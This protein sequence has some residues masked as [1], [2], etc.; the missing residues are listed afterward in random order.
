MFLVWHIM[1]LKIETPNAKHSVDLIIFLIR[2]LM[3]L[4]GLKNVF[5][6]IGGTLTI[7]KVLSF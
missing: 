7:Q 4:S 3:T 2:L 6:E 5:I 1:N